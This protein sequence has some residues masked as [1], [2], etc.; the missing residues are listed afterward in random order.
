MPQAVAP[1][2]SAVIGHVITALAQELCGKIEIGQVPCGEIC[3]GY[4]PRGTCWVNCGFQLGAA[5]W[6][7]EN[8]GFT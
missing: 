4:L 2:S 8:I 7:V 1:L 3:Y 5:V 6:E